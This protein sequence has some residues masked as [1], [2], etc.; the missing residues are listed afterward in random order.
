[1]REIDDTQ[2]DAAESD[3]REKYNTYVYDIIDDQGRTQD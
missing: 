3:I 2:L 1:M